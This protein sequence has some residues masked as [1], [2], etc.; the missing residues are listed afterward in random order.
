M[1]EVSSAAIAILRLV[2]G[3]FG[4]S[5]LSGDISTVADLFS[6]LFQ[7]ASDLA[8]AG[9]N[10]E[11]RSFEEG[12]LA[13]VIKMQDGLHNLRD[14]LKVDLADMTR[15]I[16]H[17]PSGL[18]DFKRIAAQYDGDGTAKRLLGVS[19]GYIIH[20][21][22][23]R[24]NDN[25]GNHSSNHGQGN[26]HTTPP[27]ATETS[28]TAEPKSWLLNTVRGTSRED[29]EAFV[30]K[31]PD[32]GNGRRIIYPAVGYQNYATKMTLEQVKAVSKDPIVDQVASNEPV[33]VFH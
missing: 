9:D 29:F 7:D 15:F 2:G 16:T 21:G 26:Q 6:G 11:L 31:L 14:L 24:Y 12:E 28:S 32:R 18:V 27:S 33:R 22:D 17:P 5:L 23:H 1:E 20:Y 25:G 8:A 3:E 19:L 13:D 10:I 30:G 4:A